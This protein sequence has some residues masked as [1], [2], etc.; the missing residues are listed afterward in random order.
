[1]GRIGVSALQ[2]GMT[3]A[4]PVLNARRQ[5]LAE[6]RTVLDARKIS[7][8]QSWGIVDVEVQGVAEPSLHEIEERMASTPALQQLST[9]IDERFY[10]AE[11][12]PVLEEL[13]RLVKKLAL[14]EREAEKR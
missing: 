11:H 3:L 10:G 6:A 9:E 14:E 5:C 12:H 8:F 2:P 4:G 13:R 1:M 7:L